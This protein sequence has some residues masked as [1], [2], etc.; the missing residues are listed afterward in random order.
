MTRLAKGIGDA[1][2]RSI[3]VRR[4]VVRSATAAAAET[5]ALVLDDSVPLPACQEDV[6]DL[7]ERLREH[8]VALTG[9]RAVWRLDEAPEQPRRPVVQARALRRRKVPSD[10]VGS[11]I[12]LVHL[13][14]STQHLLARAADDECGAAARIACPPIPSHS[15]A[16]NRAACS[17]AG[18]WASLRDSTSPRGA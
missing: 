3:K 11:R 8:I 5:V 12:H 15:E 17:E 1:L 9:L 13:A 16:H 6:D 2:R 14:E 10:Y 18:R 4:R 7:A